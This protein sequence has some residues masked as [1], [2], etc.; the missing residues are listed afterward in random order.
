[1]QSKQNRTYSMW[2]NTGFMLRTAWPH[3][4]SVPLLCLA[5]AVVTAG[6]TVAELLIAPAILDRVETAAPLGQLVRTIL[7]FSGVI[8]LLSGLKAYLNENTLFGRISV[9]TKIM[10]M[11]NS[12]KAGTSYA[13][14]L[15]TRFLNMEEKARDA[16][17]SNQK[18]T[19]AV[20]TTW[21]AIL[22]N[23]LGFVVYLALLSGLHPLLMVVVCV[24]AAAGYFIN[25]RIQQ[26]GYRHREEQAAYDKQL[27][28]L[29]STGL[30]RSYAKDI[31]IFGLRG[32]LDEVWN[33]TLRL[34]QAFLRKRESVYIWS[35]VVDLV[36]ALAR[37]G[38]AYGY[39]IWLT[40]HDGLRASEF[41]LYFSAVSGFS[42][43]I[44]GILEQFSTL[45][46][47]SLDIS[48]VREFLE[49]PEPFRFEDGAPLEKDLQTPYELRLEDVSFRYPE[50]EA[51]T[52]RHIDLTIHPGENLAIVGLNGAGKTT[53]V[54]L[55]C[56]FLDPTEGR[57][58][59]NGQDIRQYNRKDYYR[60]F[61][62]VF[63][64]FSVLDATVAENVAQQV[65]GIDE[66]RVW[67]CLEQAGLTETI[68]KLPNGLQTH[69]GRQV[70]EDGIELSGGQTQ[71]LMLARALYKDGAIL[72]LDEPTAALD[73]IAENDIYL[74]Y[75]E[76][77]A[78]RTS[79]FI[80]HRLASTRFCDRILFVDGGRIAEE[81]TH[82]SLLA[83]GGG[84]ARLFEVQSQYYQEG[85]VHHVQ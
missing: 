38:V 73:P 19:E 82:E 1:M 45:Y 42:T 22:T 61:S 50:A 72:A 56:G 9:R 26:W 27:G 31:R 30:D 79:L 18:A 3:T 14:L 65:D 85:D 4:K 7:A 35:S 48:T 68:R 75:N 15:D 80:S 52:L 34:Y 43:W 44:T 47:Q 84:Y 20:W 59:L 17:N 25:K 57:V 12:K 78:G 67:T 83:L 36:L 77:T 41:L 60:L 71:R 74:K 11:I 40:L 70:W 49:W 6:Q 53:L 37:N 29:R 54:K 23:F 33:K 8:L 51:D 21:T 13:N 16:T 2:Q 76:M 63:Q 32:W 46:Q 28:Y 66:Q 5:L 69:I 64:D 62:A 24:T 10:A 39:L 55:L 58:L 81:G